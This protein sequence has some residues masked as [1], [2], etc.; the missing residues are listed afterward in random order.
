MKRIAGRLL[1]GALALAASAGAADAAGGGGP[2]IP[3]LSP[4]PTFSASTVPSNG[5]LNPYGVAFVP[6]GF[7]TGGPLQAGDILVSNFN[8]SANVQGTGTTIVRIDASGHQS[9]FFQG[10]SPLGLTTAL[11]V[12]R[13]GFVLVGNVPTI[14]PSATCVTGPSGQER[15]VGHGSLLVL[16]PHGDVVRE[17]RDPS[18]LDGPWDLTVSDGGDH[19]SVFVSDVLNGTVTRVDLALEGQSVDVRGMTRIASGYAHRCDPAALVVGPTGLALDQGGDVLYVASTGD[20]AIFAVQDPFGAGANG[21]TGRA[22]IQDPAHLHGPLALARASNGDL[23]TSQGDAVNPDPAQ[24]S[25]IVEYTAAGRF[26]AQF[27]IDPAPGSAFG[28]ALEPS[29]D[30]FVFAAVDDGTN[31][32]DVWV[33]NRER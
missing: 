5:D 27:S 2:V 4:T 10:R 12:L 25:E 33:V 29:A 23:V 24:P 15:G 16:D 28:L 18:F 26:V 20:N 21:G 11:G 3:Q 7:P 8:D 6:A 14:T 30:G 32:L 31:V 19:A 1:G 17:L 9:L 22:V 13:A